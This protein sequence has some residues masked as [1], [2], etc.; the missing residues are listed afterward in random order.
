LDLNCLIIDTNLID[1]TKKARQVY[2]TPV[3]RKNEF[4]AIDN[5]RAL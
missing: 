1:D 4:Q 5:T 2:F 3:Y